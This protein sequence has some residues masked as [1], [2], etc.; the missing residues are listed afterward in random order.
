MDD[1]NVHYYLGTRD[2]IANLCMAIRM[3]GLTPALRQV[4]ESFRER[5]PEN[6]HIEPALAVLEQVER[7]LTCNQKS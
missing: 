1:N 2:A 3:Y 6:P 7:K 5:N 4:I